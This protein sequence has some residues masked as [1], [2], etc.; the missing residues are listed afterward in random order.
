MPP[1]FLKKRFISLRR[2][3]FVFEQRLVLARHTFL[4]FKADGSLLT[5]QFL[6]NEDIFFDENSSSI[7]IV[8]SAGNIISSSLIV[9]LCFPG[10]Q[11]P[12]DELINTVALNL[13]LVLF[14]RKWY[15]SGVLDCRKSSIA[16]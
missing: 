14:E 11:N 5:R 1:P 9:E 15:C 12:P 8:R 2:F 6:Y 13:P 16:G 4:L 10:K 3:F 7:L